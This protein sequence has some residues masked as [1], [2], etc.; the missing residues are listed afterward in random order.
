MRHLVSFLFPVSEVKALI[1]LDN[2]FM[3]SLGGASIFAFPSYS[4][5]LPPELVV[6]NTNLKSFPIQKL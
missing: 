4:I 1:S 5:T 3:L 2:K 6:L